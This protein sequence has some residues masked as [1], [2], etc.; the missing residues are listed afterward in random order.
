[1]VFDA[2][3]DTLSRL[4]YENISL[5]ETKVNKTNLNYGAQ[6]FACF[7]R[8]NSDNK[9]SECLKMIRRFYS[10]NFLLATNYAEMSAI[11]DNGKTA[12][13]LSIEGADLIEKISDLYLL[14]SL[15]V[16]FLSLTWN[17]DNDL[18]G[19]VLEGKH[20]VTKFGKIII[21]EMNKIGIIIDVSHLS[22]NSFWEVSD[23]SYKPFIASHSNS[24]VCCNNKRNLTDRQFEMIRDKK[25]MVG[26]NFCSDFLNDRKNAT[27]KDVILHIEHFLSLG[28]EDCIGI[29][30]DYDGT[31]NIPR[32]LE[33]PSK[34]AVLRDELIK[35][36]YSYELTD[37]ILYKNFMIFVKNNL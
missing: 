29:G 6:C 7:V 33:N 37:K 25:G 20:G 13:F 28:G 16:R 11:I 18:A 36:N 3:C 23:I 15:G 21:Q 9:F 4:V 26:I 19:G 10:E 5:N 35:L 12:A 34:I 24:F 2:H 1:M 22:E 32:E 31:V 8:P 27:V 14:Y 17:Y 30:S